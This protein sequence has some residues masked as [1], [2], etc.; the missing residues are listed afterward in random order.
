MNRKMLILT[1]LLIVGGSRVSA[2][3]GQSGAPYGYLQA[4]P[5]QSPGQPATAGSGMEQRSL[6]RDCIH[7][8]EH[9][10][11]HLDEL[12]RSAARRPT[13]AD[14]VQ[15]HLREVRTAVTSMLEDHR[16]FL[17]MLTE[18]QWNSTQDSITRLQHLRATISAQLEGFDDE[19]R[20][21]SPDSRV[22]VRYAK[23]TKRALQE[24]QKRHRKMGATLG[25]RDR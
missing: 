15:W 21:P 14:K 23:K 20:M 25:M 8:A 13:Q 11:M 19:L 5:V 4:L 1:A 22:L 9:A 2:Y 16:R 24:W 10:R 6:F 18:E 12:L 3:S 7:T 17:Y